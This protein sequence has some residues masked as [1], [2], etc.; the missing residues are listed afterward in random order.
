MMDGLE[1]RRQRR[2]SI[3]MRRVGVDTVHAT[4]EVVRE[5]DDVGRK[6]DEA[7]VIKPGGEW[8]A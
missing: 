5:N 1:V 2:M 3:G 6:T 8:V 4:K 7:K